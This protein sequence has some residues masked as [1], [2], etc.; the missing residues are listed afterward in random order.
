M[1]K[2]DRRTALKLVSVN[3]RAQKHGT[4]NVTALDIQLEGVPLSEEELG[5]VLQNP[6]AAQRL[7]VRTKGRPPEPVFGKV[8][9]IIPFMAKVTGVSAKLF[10]GRRLLAVQDGKLNKCRVELR[11][12]IMAWHIQIQCVPDLDETHPTMEA[13]LS[14]LGDPI[15][16]ELEC[17]SY[18]A[19]PELPFEEEE[20]EDDDD[21]SEE[22]AAGMTDLGRQIA[23]SHRRRVSKGV[24]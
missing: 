4:E 21:D 17:P 23:E 5:V 13:L 11:Q 16:L 1:L 12:G 18:G 14:R 8:A 24:E 7:L 10:L 19:Q 15:D 9:C 22:K 2:L 20:S 3:P 6:K